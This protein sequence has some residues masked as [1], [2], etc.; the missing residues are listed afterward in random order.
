MKKTDG[1]ICTVLTSSF[2]LFSSDSCLSHVSNYNTLFLFLLYILFLSLCVINV[3]SQG[4]K[5]V[6]K[7]LSFP[8]YLY[9]VTCLYT[10]WG[11][12]KNPSIPEILK[13]EF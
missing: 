5:F 1:R 13:L 2:L 11:N 6:L 10:I 3:L 4:C 12:K 8:F 9:K 7:L